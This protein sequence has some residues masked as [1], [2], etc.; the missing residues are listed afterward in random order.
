MQKNKSA[1]GPAAPT[2][3]GRITVLNLLLFG[4]MGQVAWT[5]ENQ[6]F[7]TFLYNSVGGTPSDISRMVSL[8]AVTAVL[9]T[10]II[11]TLSDKANTRKLFLCG[12]YIFWGAVV[13]AFAFITRENTARL[14]GLTDAARIRLMTVNI[15][16][17]MD[18]LMT[19]MGSTGNDAAFNAWVTD[20]T[21]DKNRAVTESILSI[22]GMAALAAVTVVFPLC[23]D[24]FGYPAAFI[25]LGIVVA[26]CGVVGIF[27][28]KDTHCGAIE[29]KPF[30][31]DLFYGFR[32][33]VIKENKKLY[34]ALAS[35]CFFSISV[36]IFFPYIFIYLQHYLGFSFDTA[37]AALTP[38]K[39]IIAA[40]A[41]IAGVAALI[42]ISK[43]ADKY[44]KEHF[45]YPLTAIYI[46]GLVLAFFAKSMGRFALSLLPLLAGYGLLN[47][48]LSAAVRDFTPENKAGQFQGI[49]MIFFVLIPMLIGP[50]VGSMVIERLSDLTYVNDYSEVVSVPIPAV[51]LAAAAAAVLILIP[52]AVL[53]RSM[54]KAAEEKIEVK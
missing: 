52:A 48:M 11:G 29:K 23:A 17:V 50:S 44:G 5:V 7:N 40:A 54:K 43:L 35:I 6:F 38:A 37:F 25:V 20:I 15:V 32:P 28:V 51:F 16:I 34:L 45:V 3:L 33:S 49:R 1:A 26:L 13:M 53:R 30:F 19:F 46:V 22:A 12:G 27:T 21:T 47:I 36:N 2:R 31:A 41:V 14:F 42:L 4:F 8:S 24:S 9:T 39:I 10:I 18:C